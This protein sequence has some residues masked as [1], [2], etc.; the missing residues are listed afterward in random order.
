MFAWLRKRYNDRFDE[1]YRNFVDSQLAEAKGEESASQPVAPTP[2]SLPKLNFGQR[3]D[4]IW[5]VGVLALWPG[6][7]IVVCVVV[8]LSQV[9]NGYDYW[10][11]PAQPYVQPTGL[12]VLQAVPTDMVK[13]PVWSDI[14]WL[15]PEEALALRNKDS[16]VNFAML[17]ERSVKYAKDQSMVFLPQEP[18]KKIAQPALFQ[19]QRVS[20]TSVTFMYNGYTY[21]LNVGQPFTSKIFPQVISVFDMEGNVWQVNDDTVPMASLKSVQSTNVYRVKPNSQLSLTQP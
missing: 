4:W 2:R 18:W 13:K 20:G 6:I 3:I 1:W 10:F 15:A 17:D 16:V 9:R 14:Q 8:L 12:P 21:V 11:S 5:N 19:A 7:L